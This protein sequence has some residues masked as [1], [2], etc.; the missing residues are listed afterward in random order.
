[1]QIE[2]NS[3]KGKE[4]EKRRGETN[5]KKIAKLPQAKKGGG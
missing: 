4:G 1:L 2:K 3:R 5:K